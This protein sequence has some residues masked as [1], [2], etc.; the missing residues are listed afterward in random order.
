M[1]LNTEWGK[2]A[3]TLFTKYLVSTFFKRGIPSFTSKV[4]WN[5]IFSCKRAVQATFNSKLAYVQLRVTI[6]THQR[7]I[8]LVF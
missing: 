7:L 5:L 1:L 2:D 8:E 3:K 6:N 4:F